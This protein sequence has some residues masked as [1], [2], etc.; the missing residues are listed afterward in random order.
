MSVP[1][2]GGG[3]SGQGGGGRGLV[4]DVTNMPGRC[5]GGGSGA[6]SAVLYKDG[7]AL[8]VSSSTRWRTMSHGSQDKGAACAL[9][10][11][12]G[13]GIAC[14]FCSILLRVWW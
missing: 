11:C 5:S 2:L 7:G 8:L 6:L 14:A 4:C 3:G 12:P 9:G 13:C 1:V 10:S